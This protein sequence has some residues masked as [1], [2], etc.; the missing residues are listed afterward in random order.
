[1][2]IDRRKKEVLRTRGESVVLEGR[3][4]RAEAKKSEEAFV[5]RRSAFNL[6]PRP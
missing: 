1:M 4:I 6:L 3:K 2:K 5:G